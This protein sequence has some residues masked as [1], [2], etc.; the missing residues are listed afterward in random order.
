MLK[1]SIDKA[2]VGMVIAADIFDP[3]FGGDFPL[4]GRGVEL[5]ASYIGRMK[6]RCIH[7]IF[8]ITPSGY[9]GA[10]GETFAPAQITEDIFFE[11]K[12]ELQCDIP[13]G[14]R[15]VAGENIF[16]KGVVNKGCSIT[17]ATG[18]IIIKGGV[19]GSD[20][21]RVTLSAAS[22]VTVT[23]E[24]TRPVRYADIKALDEIIVYGDI[25]DCT[26]STKGKLVVRGKVEKSNLYSQTR[27]RINECGDELTRTPCQLL[28]KPAECRALFQELLALDQQ[29]VMQQKE[30]DKLHNTIDLIRKLGKNIDQLPVEQKMQLATDVKQ[31]H[32]V[33]AA[34]SA[35]L[36]EKDRLKK[37]MSGV[38]AVNRILIN[39]QAHPNTKITIENMSLLLERPLEKVAFY[40]KDMKIEHDTY[41][42]E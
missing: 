17:S 14:T 4:V 36:K 2:K 7:E 26:L 3:D 9:R 42:G 13:A 25:S 8:I 35:G 40:V 41:S 39:R 16:I 11:G 1:L 28:V 18:D 5:T 34:I 21:E 32:A 6:D 27:I 23:I 12:V 24:D 29:M 10:P 15:V 33:D 20:G 37:E 19:S 30:K 31:F 38:F 22:C